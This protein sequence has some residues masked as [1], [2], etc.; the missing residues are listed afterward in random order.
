MMTVTTKTDVDD[1]K[2]IRKESC[3]NDELSTWKRIVQLRVK[4]SEAL[5]ITA[6]LLN[7]HGNDAV[8]GNIDTA[9]EMDDDLDALAVVRQFLLQQLL[10]H[11]IG[12]LM[13][14]TQ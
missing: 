8:T 3:D 4:E 11:H 10:L 6:R 14:Q 12:I 13:T 5:G 9:L 7:D 2:C 1:T